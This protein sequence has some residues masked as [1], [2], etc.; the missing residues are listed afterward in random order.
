[1]PYGLHSGAGIPAAGAYGPDIIRGL[2]ISAGPGDITGGQPFWGVFG[3]YLDRAW[4]LFIFAPLYLAFVP[5][6]PLLR[7]RRDL[8]RWWLFIPLVLLLHTIVAGFFGQ[9]FGGT[10]PVPRYLVPMIPVFVI[11]AGIFLARCRNRVV[12]AAL[13][14]LFLFQVILTVFALLYPMKVFAIYGPDNALIPEVLGNT[15]LAA[16]YV[17]VFPLLHPVR[18][19]SGI[20]LLGAWLVALTAVSIYLRRKA[21]D[22][23]YPGLELQ[24]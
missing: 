5:G 6:I 24:R 12:K 3:L 14:P 4:G 13:V 9:W 15:W 18:L 1:M 21:M 23:M 10:S 11:C 20:L 7:G 8:D 22:P 16:T 2:T 17:R 19:K